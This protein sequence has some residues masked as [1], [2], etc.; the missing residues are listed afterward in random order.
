[1]IKIPARMSLLLVG[2]GEDEV[3]ASAGELVERDGA[4]VFVRQDGGVL[5]FEAEWLARA[6]PVTE[7]LRSIFGS[8][9]EFFVLLSVGNLPDDADPT[10]YKPTGLKLPPES[11]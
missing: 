1:M 10:D 8:E 2:D 6:K 11:A 4:L 3:Y 5:P 9:S 7:D